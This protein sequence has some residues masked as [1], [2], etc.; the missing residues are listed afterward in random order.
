M[1]HAQRSVAV[2]KWGG[3][4]P[5]FDVERDP[6]RLT[7]LTARAPAE[8]ILNALRS[9]GHVT[10]VDVPYDGEGGWHFTVQ[11]E[12]RTFGVFTLWR[13]IADEDYF[14]VQLDFKR[15]VFAALF[16]K[17]VR[18]ERLEP[19]CRAIDEALASV[20]RVID[21]QWLTDEQFNKCYGSNEPLLAAERRGA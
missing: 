8:A 15:G 4:I 16:R 9:R 20:P 18:D 11:I 6:E 7:T 2:F 3:E 21:L 17:P 1:H 10:D 13:G 14:A 12:D 5:G 19:I